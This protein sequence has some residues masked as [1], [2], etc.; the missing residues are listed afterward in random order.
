MENMENYLDHPLKVMKE[1]LWLDERC[2]TDVYREQC[3][4]AVFNEPEDSL[5][6]S[7]S[8]EIETSEEKGAF[9]T[10]NEKL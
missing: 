4:K 9:E 7:T 5:E 1:R 2:A 10:L 8:D 6:E 3:D